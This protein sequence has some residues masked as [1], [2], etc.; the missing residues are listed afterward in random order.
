MLVVEGYMDVV[1]LHQHGVEYA[2]ATLGTAT[3]AAH[4]AKL[5]RQADRVV[6]AFDGDSAGQRAAWRA[7]ENALPMLSDTK[8]LDFLFLPPA[9]DPDSFIREHGL[10][11]F[12]SLVA[13]AMPLSA[14]LVRELC[15]R[16]DQAT[17][18]GRARIQAELKP[19]VKAMPDIALRD[20][21]RPGGGG[22]GR[23]R[24]R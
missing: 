19:M 15:R 6:F 12:E 13:Q 22:Q 3:T 1:M 2:V 20:P 10:E 18:E 8:R 23:R 21:D 7:L 16:A 5:L 17:P 9:H 11:A 4:L 14:Y 24:D